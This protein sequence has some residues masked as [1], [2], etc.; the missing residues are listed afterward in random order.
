VSR[1]RALRQ[2]NETL[3]ARVVARTAEVR[4][5]ASALTRAEQRERERL[6]HVLHDDLQQTLFGLDLCATALAARVPPALADD[7]AALAR[8]ARTASSTARHLAVEL[9][10]PVLVGEGLA[11]ALRWLAVH[12]GPAHGLTV[13][14]SGV[15]DGPEPA[16]ASRVLLYQ[17]ARDALQRGQARRHRPRAAGLRPTRRHARAG[18]RRR[19]P[20]LRPSS[21]GGFGLVSV[22][23]R[24]AYCGGHLDR[25][26]ALGAGTHLRACLPAAT[27]TPAPAA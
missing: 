20:R 27:S 13:D 6:S 22:R 7:V 8:H 15:E 9:A 18:G 21:A 14:A 11:P 19:R 10:P 3:E 24:L 17:V 1:G 2:L 5:L 23:D 12:A 25:W 4:A 16:E 26:T